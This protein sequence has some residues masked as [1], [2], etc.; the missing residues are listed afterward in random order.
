MRMQ[1]VDGVK[2]REA[3]ETS[4]LPIKTLHFTGRKLPYNL[5]SSGFAPL[6]K[7]N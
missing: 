5:R 4:I 3:F 1:A 2:N 7:E 6:K